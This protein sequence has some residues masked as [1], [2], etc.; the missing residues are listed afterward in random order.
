MGKCTKNSGW[1]GE[2]SGNSGDRM[3]EIGPYLPMKRIVYALC[4]E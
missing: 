2:G 1:M 4:T 3:E